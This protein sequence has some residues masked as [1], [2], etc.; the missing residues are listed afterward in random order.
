M[1]AKHP[2]IL[3]VGEAIRARRL[4]AGLSQ[5]DFAGQIDLDR[6][7]YSHIE[8]GEINISLLVLFRIAVGL[9]CA[10]SDLMPELNQL[11]GLPPPS[12][13]RGRR[14]GVAALREAEHA[15]KRSKP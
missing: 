9:G 2:S 11:K 5:E 14:K 4:G 12:K 6:A 3:V 7:Y 10:P 13:T 15:V 8:R 1:Q